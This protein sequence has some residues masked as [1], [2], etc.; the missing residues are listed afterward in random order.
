[1]PV[2]S[3]YWHCDCRG[4]IERVTYA[5]DCDRAQARVAELEKAL[6][7]LVY[8]IEDEPD[9]M[10]IGEYKRALVVLGCGHRKTGLESQNE[11]GK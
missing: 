11:G 8:A 7:G 4:H 1:M 3:P 2:S 9:I 5:Q 6:R 10:M